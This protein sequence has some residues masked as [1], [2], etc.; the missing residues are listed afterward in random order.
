MKKIPLRWL[1]LVLVTAVAIVALIY[2]APK[3]E[4][5]NY[6]IVLSGPSENHVEFQYGAWPQLGDVNFFNN[7]LKKFINER[8]D[9]IEADLDQMKLSVFK[10]GEKVKEVPII[11]KGK[12]GSWWETPVGLYKIEA[13]YKNAYSSFAGVYMPYSLVFEG[14]FLIHGWPYYSSGK[15]VASTYSGG[16]I[17]LFDEDAKEIYNLV[18]VGMPV[19]VFKKAFE[20]ENS[21]YQYKIPELT[22]QAYLAADLK[23]NFVFLEKN[24][25]QIIPIASVTKLI[26]SLVVLDHTNLEYYARVPQEALV[27]TSIPRLKAGQKISIF[28]LLALLLVESSNEAGNTL[29]AFLGPEKTVSWMNDQAKSIGMI[30]SHFV[31]P[32]GVSL[33]NV[34]TPLDL[35]QLSKYLYFNRSFVLRMTKGVFDNDY[36]GKPSYNLKNLN[37]FADDPNFVGGKMGLTSGSGETMLSV[38]ELSLGSEEKRPIVFIALNSKDVYTD[39]IK[40]VEFVKNYYQFEN[41]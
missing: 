8:I 39:I 17:R 6:S 16:C 38:F 27:F 20:V 13:K 28:D 32:N 18:E 36:Y 2:Y 21:T 37:L 33:E 5:K 10:N 22:A 15:P 25:S 11:A 12:E 26:T 14:N 41:E 35:Y 9:F 7:V 31:D 40:M 30:N 3:K 24:R 4:I 1:L 23:N 29:A 19:L 34:S